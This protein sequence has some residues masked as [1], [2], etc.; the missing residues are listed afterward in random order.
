V[1]YLQALVEVDLMAMSRSKSASDLPGSQWV[2][3]EFIA[4]H[5]SLAE[6]M[7]E[8][9]WDDGK[10]R[11]TGTILIVA[12]GRVLKASVHD[13]DARRSAWVSADTLCELLV[14]IDAALGT[15]S[16]EWRKDTR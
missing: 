7:R 3:E 10:P 13:R 12:D 11:K 4:S 14:R 5:P 9:S 16:L 2:D 1:V 15:D 8:T 6:F